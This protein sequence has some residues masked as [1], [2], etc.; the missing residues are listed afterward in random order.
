MEM[1]KI[2]L[3]VAGFDPSSGAGVLLDLKVFHQL[4]FQ[5]MSILTSLTAQNT[6][7]VLKIHCLPSRFLWEQYEGLEADVSFSGIKVGMV[8]SNDNI[9]IISKI[10]SRNK[11]IPKV[12]DPVFK[13]SSGTWLLKKEFIQGYISAISGKASLL[14]PN[15]EEASLISGNQ[16]KNIEDLKA[17]AEKIYSQT[18]IPCYIKGM[19]I[20]SKI[21]DLLYD[22]TKFYSF[23]NARIK[24]RIHG[25]GCFLSSSILGFLA[26]GHPLKKACL[27][28]SQF[29]HQVMQ[30]AVRLGNGQHIIPFPLKKA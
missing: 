25:T 1:K 29:T 15:L 28:A 14:T 4:H 8:G 21:I 24:K 18:K 9:Q 26:K 12:I 3:S 19:D 5:G 17:T 23:E 6:R 13:S 7:E 2:L 27:L 11:N 10:L 16:I 22:G 30:K 20:K